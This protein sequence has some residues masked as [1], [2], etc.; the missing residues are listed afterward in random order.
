MSLLPRAIRVARWTWVG[1][2]VKIN[3][4]DRLLEVT[5]ISPNWKIRFLV[6]SLVRI[7]ARKDD[8]SFALDIFEENKFR[9]RDVFCTASLKKT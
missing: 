4:V 8:K 5:R 3:I 6:E 2:D 7:G 9:E 1:L